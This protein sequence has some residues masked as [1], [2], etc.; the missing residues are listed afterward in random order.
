MTDIEKR[1]QALEDIEAIKALHRDYIYWLNNSEW[2]R[3]VDCFTEDAVARIFRHP[4]CRGKSDI[5]A[6]FTQTMSTVNAGKGRDCH[7]STMPV[8]KVDGDSA[9][10]HWMLYILIADQQSGKADKWAQGRYE[11]AYQR[12]AD[13]WKINKL[14]WI[15]PWP[16]T[17]DTLPKM[18]D[19]NEVID[20]G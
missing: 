3:M 12:V 6:L 20:F 17:N 10:G 4:L 2:D 8:I 14:V 7:F 13:Q 9:T 1:V 18:K 15:N 11:C 19:I 16:I 5:H